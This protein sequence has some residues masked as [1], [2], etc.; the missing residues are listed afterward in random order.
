MKHSLIQ[1]KHC[2]CY[3]P[4]QKQHKILDLIHVTQVQ[5]FLDQVNNDMNK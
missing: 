4:H 1:C 2:Q 3:E 5:Q